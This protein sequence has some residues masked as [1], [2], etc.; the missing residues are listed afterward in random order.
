MQLGERHFNTS[1]IVYA[2]KSPRCIYRQHP[3]C[4]HS[5]QLSQYCLVGMIYVMP[6]W[7]VRS[8]DFSPI[9]YVRDVL[10]N[11]LQASGN[12]G[13]L[14]AQLQRLWHNS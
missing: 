4:P 2:I 3:D 6:P 12:T 11:Y 8:P 9:Q 14:T 7:R 5:A 1:C 10:G 13:E